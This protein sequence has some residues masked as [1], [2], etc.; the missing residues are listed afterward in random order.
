[1]S[2]H[3]SISSPRVFSESHIAWTLDYVWEGGEEHAVLCYCALRIEWCRNTPLEK[4]SGG[5]WFI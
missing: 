2:I 4:A 3:E 5:K 1:M